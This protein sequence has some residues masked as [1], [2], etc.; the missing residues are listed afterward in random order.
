MTWYMSNLSKSALSKSIVGAPP[1]ASHNDFRFLAIGSL[2]R[3][4][5]QPS[6][7]GKMFLLPATAIP[8][9][10][11]ISAWQSLSV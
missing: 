5:S 1:G 11:A 4:E 6:I 9:A 8:G 2:P 3:R 7:H 10:P